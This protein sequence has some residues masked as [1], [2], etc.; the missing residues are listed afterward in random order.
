MPLLFFGSILWQV[1]VNLASKIKHIGVGF[2]LKRPKYH[3]VNFCTDRHTYMDQKKGRNLRN[4]SI[5]F[6]LN[7]V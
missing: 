2:R 6:H 1:T 4:L 7:V 3:F 5:N